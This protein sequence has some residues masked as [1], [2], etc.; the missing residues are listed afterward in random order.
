LCLVIESSLKSTRIREKKILL[1]EETEA[2]KILQTEFAG[3]VSEIGRHLLVIGKML[4]N[5]E[6]KLARLENAND[7]LAE[8]YE[9][10]NGNEGA[11]Q[12]QTVLDEESEM[13][14][15][16]I[17]KVS[18]LEV[19]QIELEWR[20][21]ESAER[22]YSEFGERSKTGTTSGRNVNTHVWSN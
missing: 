16:I 17:D 13:I 7:K 14:G 3:D 2:E 18:Q 19:L 6:T 5:L 10:N 12:F 15:G 1:K 9:Q 20:R 8:A 4:L 22:A 11:E 21:R